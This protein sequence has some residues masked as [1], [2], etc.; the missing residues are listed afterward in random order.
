MV[1]PSALE[2]AGLS[3]IVN[4]LLKT[5]NPVPFDFLIDGVFLRTSLLEYLKNQ[6]LSGENVIDIEFVE[7]TL[8]PMFKDSCDTESWISSVLVLSPTISGFTMKY[9]VGSYDKSI[10]IWG[11][12][13]EIESKL[14]GHGGPVKSLCVAN[15]SFSYANSEKTHADLLS[16]GLDCTVIGWRS[17][18]KVT[19]GFEPV[20]QAI[21]H[22]GSIESI[23]IDSE[24]TNFITGST[25]STIKLWTLSIPEKSEEDLDSVSKATYSGHQGAVNCVSFNTLRQTQ[26]FSGGF[27]HTLRTWDVTTG[28]CTYTKSWV[29]SVKWSPTSQH[30]FASASYDGQ[31]KVWDIRSRFPM[32]TVAQPGQDGNKGERTRVCD[33]EKMENETERVEKFSWAEYLQNQVVPVVRT[34]KTKERIAFFSTDLISKLEEHPIPEKAVVVL[35][36][37]VFPT[38]RKYVDRKSR[39]SVL[40]FLK[41]I[42]EKYPAAMVE[43]VKTIVGAEVDRLFPASGVTTANIKGT[44]DDRFQL[45]NWINVAIKTGLQQ[46]GN[47]RMDKFDSTLSKLVDC[48]ARLLFGLCRVGEPVAPGAKSGGS[49]TIVAGGQEGDGAREGGVEGRKTDIMHQSGLADVRR[50]IRSNPQAIP[51]FLEE[52]ASGRGKSE[53]YGSVLL[54]NVVST[55][56]RLRN[57]N[58]G[59]EAVEAKKDVI[60]KYIETNI[61]SAKAAVPYSAVDALGEFI[62]S[63]VDEA[64]FKN[65]M[66]PV[67]KRMIL[68]GPEVVFMV[69]NLVLERVEFDVGPVF[70]SELADSLV[71]TVLKSTNVMVRRNGVKLFLRALS[72]SQNAESLMGITEII[73][74]ALSSG[75]AVG[76]AADA[77][78]SFYEMLRGLAAVG[79]GDVSKRVI[80]Q[81]LVQLAKESIET[82]VVGLIEIIGVH[83][84]VVLMCE[85]NGAKD[86]IE[87]IKKVAEAAGKVVKQQ[88]SKSGV[89]VKRAWMTQVL[90]E[91]VWKVMVGQVRSLE[92]TEMLGKEAIEVLSKNQDAGFNEVVEG[93]IGLAIWL[94]LSQVQ[95]HDEQRAQA[96]KIVKGEERKGGAVYLYSDKVLHKAT[97]KREAIWLMRALEGIYMEPTVYEGNEWQREKFVEALMTVIEASKRSQC[98]ANEVC[99]AVNRMVKSNG[100]E[101]GSMIE[102]YGVQQLQKIRQTPLSSTKTKEDGEEEEPQQRGKKTEIGRIYQTF[103]D[104]DYDKEQKAQ[105]AMQ[106]AL[107]VHNEENGQEIWISLVQEAGLDVR[108][109]SLLY[110]DKLLERAV[111][112]IVNEQGEQ[113]GSRLLETLSFVLGEEVI[114]TILHRASKLVKESNVKS[115]GSTEQKIWNTPEG[116]L[117]ADL[118]EL[119][120]EDSKSQGGTGSSAERKWE[121]EVRAQI[122]LKK[123]GT[124]GKEEQK[125]VDEQLKEEK[126][127][128]EQIGWQARKVGAA[129]EMIA[130]IV[131]GNVDEAKNYVTLMYRILLQEIAGE[132]DGAWL[133]GRQ[134]RAAVVM[135][136]KQLAEG[137]N[138]KHIVALAMAILRTNSKG[139]YECVDEEWTKEPIEFM[140]TRLLFSLRMSSETEV[141]S[142]TDFAIAFPLVQA[143]IQAGGYGEQRIEGADEYTTTSQR[144]EQIAMLAEI[145]LLNWSRP[146]QRDNRELRVESLQSCLVIMEKFSS[147]SLA[148]GIEAVEMICAQTARISEEMQSSVGEERKVVLRG[149]LSKDSAIRNG[150]LVGLRY[151]NFDDIDTGD[152]ID[153]AGIEQI[154]AL[155]I[156]T[157]DNEQASSLANSEL[158]TTLF[159]TEFE[160]DCYIGQLMEYLIS[161]RGFLMHNVVSGEAGNEW[162]NNRYIHKSS[163]KAIAE[164]VS[165]LWDSNER[166]KNELAEF[167]LVGLKERYRQYYISLEPELDQY[168]LVIAGTSNKV[169]PYPVRVAIGETL[170]LIIPV[171][172][173][174]ANSNDGDK[175]AIT[176]VMDFL[177]N[178]KAL[179]DRDEQVRDVML[180]LGTTLV[181]SYGEGSQSSEIGHR[182][183]TWLNSTASGAGSDEV[184]D[185]MKESV[186]VL[187][188][189]LASYLPEDNGANDG[190]V[191]SATQNLTACLH[192]PSESVQMAVANCL[193][194]LVKRINTKDE[195]FVGEL[196]KQLLSEL[197]VGKKYGIRRGAAYGLAGVVKGGG[198]VVLRN[199][200]I[201]KKLRNFANDKKSISTRQGALFGVETLSI[202]LGRLFEPYMI[203]ILPVLLRLFGDSS[204]DVREATSDAA[205]AIMGQLSGYGVKLVVPSLL[206]G[207]SSESP[208]RTKVGSIEMLGSMAFCAPKQLSSAL[209]AIVPDLVESLSDTHINVSQAAKQALANFGQVIQN[210]EI[211]DM[212]PHLLLALEDPANKTSPALSRLI[213]TAFVHY[214]DAPSLALIAPV[215]ERGLKERKTIDKRQAAQVFGS[216]AVLSEPNDLVL[217]LPKVMPLL[218]DVLADPVPETRA[219]VAKAL[220][221]LVSKLGEERFPTLVD[222]LLETLQSK[223]SGMD[224]AGAAQALSE[225]VYGIELSTEVDEQV[226]DDR[227][228]ALVDMTLQK[229]CTSS[230]FYVRE[231]FMTLLMYLPSTFGD[232][233]VVYLDRVVNPV[234]RGLADESEHV[235][236]AALKAGQTLVAFYH[237]DEVARQQLLSELL[238]GL[239]NDSWRIRKASVELLGDLLMKVLGHVALGSGL[240][241]SSSQLGNTLFDEDEDN[242]E[243]IMNQ[244]S[245]LGANNTVNNASGLLAQTFG[246]SQ[247]NY[248]FASLYITRNDVVASVRQASTL[249][250]KALIVNT[251]RTIKECLE[252]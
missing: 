70:K 50:V 185:V 32:Y 163:V 86:Y 90:G 200:D 76:T 47:N 178:D 80:E 95:K 171:I 138:Q 82:S 194:P 224:R 107:L 187:L 83:T 84:E 251:P 201:V 99:A 150:C 246:E 208:W 148:K 218:I 240:L 252:P 222:D 13:L 250:W 149:L 159:Y 3:E 154:A 237:K 8:P 229:G 147:N 234:L 53:M 112:A 22:T 143:T 6:N 125:K 9:I 24:S 33:E 130:S 209:P 74:K 239:M 228:T 118:T 134:L 29:S 132:Q 168:G 164:A 37:A 12:D 230:L 161:K 68:R 167:V 242:E 195:Q 146:H 44:A 62:G 41:K 67:A 227:L 247:R 58:D 79:N 77:R 216:L 248:I 225:V 114:E 122:A 60:L 18:D 92:G 108:E 169:D 186:V 23:S 66:V 160:L 233:F 39:L 197:T 105:M 177:L 184:H 217:Y 182:L 65:K 103:M 36:K 129:I 10:Q 64:V 38:T 196:I 215:L 51:A 52:L 115:L 94:K 19:E 78:S 71:Q 100:V 244:L 205:K 183:E 211:I 249:V 174:N 34:N 7:S 139:S 193:V 16:G 152:D 158:A 121:A 55:A 220:G 199:H 73:L 191:K 72:K 48:Q 165:L 27:D 109:V 124:L 117:A 113:G 91:P 214:V 40:G 212:V 145:I 202:M 238:N 172:S 207:L 137:V 162:Y 231:G 245:Q 181:K 179:G 102:K 128:R 198:L 69:L 110:S 63:Y 221:K 133:V 104:G 11:S 4:R 155:W 142:E 204:A 136:V 21:G 98:M 46:A 151:L 61:V 87:T 59:K 45:L 2:K 176:H 127:I 88:G 30:T 75:K 226:T 1:V 141:F 120:R 89:A 210:P 42:G 15:R 188:G 14:E 180:K 116:E 243:E 93:F 49:S 235:R 157:C 43:G 236:S 140:V 131:R 153:V 119:M 26:F 135:I 20:Y 175:M 106:L 17:S 96:I 189:T 35:L 28:D 25:D 166:D 144:E 97:E 223:V 203:Q 85:A 241:G 192:T 219:T 81:V 173:N 126:K 213:N 232:R 206:N 190:R 56:N 170:D 57:S 111:D 31:I 156:A 5:E 123:R 101:I 54:G